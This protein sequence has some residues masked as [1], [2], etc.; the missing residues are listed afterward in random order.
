MILKPTPVGGKYK[1]FHAFQKF[2]DNQQLDMT[3]SKIFDNQAKVH[4]VAVVMLLTMVTIVSAT[5]GIH[6]STGLIS[7]QDTGCDTNGHCQPICLGA[8]GCCK[9][10]TIASLMYPKASSCR[11]TGGF[12]GR[13]DFRVGTCIC[14]AELRNQKP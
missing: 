1:S 10:L 14:Y 12:S 8:L 11:D 4:L 2:P 7:R 3:E 5:P 6:G 9:S 13:K